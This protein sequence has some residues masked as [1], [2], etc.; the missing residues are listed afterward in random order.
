MTIEGT[1]NHAVGRTVWLLAQVRGYTEK[2]QLAQAIGFSPSLMTRKIKGTVPWTVDELEKTAEVLGLSNWGDLSRPL[3][4]LVGVTE[5]TDGGVTGGVTRR[6][7]GAT[8][9]P[10]DRLAQVLPWRQ[11]YRSVTSNPIT[12][13]APVIQ[14]DASRRGGRAHTA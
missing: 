9:H 8:S 3:A 11:S 5:A 1:A 12:P 2:Q 14:M 10:N 13:S 6:Y 7:P 4:E